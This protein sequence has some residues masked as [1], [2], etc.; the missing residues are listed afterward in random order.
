[1][2]KL[3]LKK[4]ETL[5]EYFI[6]KNDITNIL[7]AISGG[8]DSIYLIKTLERLKRQVSKPKLNLSYIYIDHQWKKSSNTQVKHII[9]HI[10]L[11]KS[12]MIIYQINKKT[13]SEDECRKCRYNIIIQ[14]AIKYKF[15]L[16]ITGHSATDKIETFI[17][18]IIKG[19]G[20]ESLSSLSIKSKISSKIFILRPLLN[21]DREM[22]YWMC[23]KF[24]LSIWSDSTN[25]FYKIQRNR[26]RQELIPYIKKYL[27]INIEN[28]I[29]SLI[30][31]YHYQNEYIKQNTIKLYIKSQHNKRAAINYK[32]INTQ[33]FILQIKIIQLFCFHNFQMY[34]ENSKLIKIIY[35]INIKSIYLSKIISCN[36][37]NFFIN[38]NWFYLNIKKSI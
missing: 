31:N 35:Y 12:N 33:N 24:Y 20:I 26:I 17:Q 6:K 30:N 13:L 32:K 4:N 1:M 14:H 27:H 23:K 7:I 2:K 28:N 5:I 18:N 8:Q 15:Q 21:L 19:S 29:I 25:Y 9:S 11:I 10:K 38:K 3:N 22:I 37:F 36:N 34:L 16:I